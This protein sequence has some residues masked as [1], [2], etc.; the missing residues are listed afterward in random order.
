MNTLAITLS[1]YIYVIVIYVFIAI[2]IFRG[3]KLISQH[4]QQRRQHHQQRR[5]YQ[6]IE[7]FTQYQP[8]TITYRIPYEELVDL[9]YEDSHNVH[10]KTVKRTAK[11][12]IETLKLADR[13]VYSIESMLDEIEDYLNEKEKELPREDARQALK[14]INKMDSTYQT[15]QIPEREV[16]RLVWE[17]INHPINAK[18]IE[19]LKENFVNQLADCCRDEKSVHCCEGR[20]TR[21]LQSLQNSDAEDIVNLRPMWAFKEEIEN[22]ISKYR[23][24]LLQKTPQKYH[25]DEKLTLD[26]LDRELLSHFND[27]LVK[28][29]EKRFYRDYLEDGY[30]TLNELND[31]TKPYYDSFY[32]Y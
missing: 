7:V 13:G 28:N 18:N 4:Y 12:A 25:L 19:Q 23:Q 2:L 32:D 27:C 29:L 31:I 8:V 3:F 20:I 21:I 11:M 22:K 30:L 5:Q 6:V 10:N 24:K 14:S 16:L 1:S 15:A 26:D 17:R 9:D